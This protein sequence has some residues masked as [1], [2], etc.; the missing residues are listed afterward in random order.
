ML[1]AFSPLILVLFT[2]CAEAKDRVP[3]Q[4]SI[5][6]LLRVVEKKA[7]DNY[8]EALHFLDSTL[9]RI[10]DAPAFASQYLY[11]KMKKSNVLLMAKAHSKAFQNLLEI[12]SVVNGSSDVMIKGYY[13]TMMA[14][15]YGD[16]GNLE[17][18]IQYYKKALELYEKAGQFRNVAIAYNNIAD[19]Y[20]ANG[21]YEKAVREI[22][23]A[24]ALHEQHQFNGVASIYSTAGEI[25]LS[26]KNYKEALFYFNRTLAVIDS[27]P[28]EPLITFENDLSMASAFIGIKEFAKAK[29]LIDKYKNRISNE[30]GLAFQYYST[31]VGYFKAIHRFDSA[32]VYSEKA[33]KLST[34]IDAQKSLEAVE[35]VK[36]NE[37]YG[38]ENSLLQL[39]IEA[40][41]VEQK[42]YLLILLLSFLSVGILVYAIVVKR[43]DY[44]LLKTRNDEI[45]TQSEE[46]RA[47][48]DELV[49][50]GEALK[51]ANEILEVKVDERTAK[52]KAKNAQ[53]TQYAFFNAHRLRAPI[54]TLLGLNQLLSLSTSRE[55]KD[56]I[57]GQIFITTERFDEIVRECQKILND[58]DADE[59]IER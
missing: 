53:L 52:L 29:S 45:A 51:Q 22:N 12:E 39:Q 16:Q 49:A 28:N 42:L 50:Q 36:M 46:L 18:A 59:T 3:D 35:I 23:K 55:E 19:S 5:D 13:A 40:K 47:M 48:T 33:L 24:I 26:L 6:S 37:R 31:L 38:Y 9:S 43:R 21:D 17:I 56:E 2:L 30:A 27:N 14:F 25:Q 4:R 44:K 32:L 34:S 57:I 11:I 15:I 41:L 20:N 58:F 7:Q 1:R 10:K 54:A 8:G